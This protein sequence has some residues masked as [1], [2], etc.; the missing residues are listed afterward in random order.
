MKNT[1]MVSD[2]TTE[3]KQS[4]KE[5]LLTIMFHGC[6]GNM[7]VLSLLVATAV[8]GRTNIK[9]GSDFANTC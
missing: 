5:N 8:L 3:I 4:K 6:L 1:S 9:A 7:R 2:L